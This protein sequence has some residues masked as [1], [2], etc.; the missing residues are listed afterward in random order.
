M[1]SAEIIRDLC[2]KNKTSIARLEKELGLGNGTIASSKSNYMRS[3]RLKAV[4]DYFH[5][6]M[7]YLMTGVDVSI[8]S[9]V[10]EH[11][12]LHDL[13]FMDYV[14]RLWNLPPE[15]KDPILRNIK[16]ESE[17]YKKELGEKDAQKRA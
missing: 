6:S 9:K 13:A 12:C 8:E 7:E 17:D 10:T 2:A 5:V 16:F 15:R 14:M 11:P 3:D 4:A 1:E